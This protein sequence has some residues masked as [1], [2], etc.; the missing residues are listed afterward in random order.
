MSAQLL[1]PGP[2][3]DLEGGAH[4]RARCRFATSPLDDPRRA[5]TDM[6]CSRYKGAARDGGLTARW[7]HRAHP[8]SLRLSRH[9]DPRQIKLLGID[10]ATCRPPLPD[11]PSE[12]P[13]PMRS[14]IVLTIE[15]PRPEPNSSAPSAR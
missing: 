5:H 4:C 14:A 2:A 11:C 1:K 7:V 6:K 15:R 12:T 8:F 3:T 10:T 13:A 9:P